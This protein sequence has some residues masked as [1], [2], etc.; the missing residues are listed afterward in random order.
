M[1]EQQDFWKYIRGE[2]YPGCPTPKTEW[3]EGMEADFAKRGISM[4][5]RANVVRVAAKTAVKR[6]K[7]KH[8]SKNEYMKQRRAKA[9]KDGM[10]ADCAHVKARKGKTTCQPCQDKRTEREL[11]RH[12]AKTSVAA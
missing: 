10:C 11:K 12:Y 7:G 9:I 2:W 1:S 5:D 4:D 3:R 6:A 8:Q